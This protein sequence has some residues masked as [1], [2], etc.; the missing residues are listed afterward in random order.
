MV[1]T[2]N[3][4]SYLLDSFNR[5]FIPVRVTAVV[6]AAIARDRAQLFAEAL[7]AYR[8]GELPMLPDGLMLTDHQAD[9]R[10]QNPL[11]TFVADRLAPDAWGY[12]DGAKLVELFREKQDMKYEA[13]HRLVY[14]DSLAAL[15]F[16]RHRFA[17][18]ATGDEAEAPPRVRCL[19]RV[20]PG[21]R[22]PS[23]RS[24]YA[25]APDGRKVMV[26]EIDLDPPPKRHEE[27][28]RTAPPS[29]TP[30]FEYDESR[31]AETAAAARAHAAWFKS[32][33]E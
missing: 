14:G 23:Q 10:I 9:R 21:W 29:P 18:G 6:R 3:A 1:G 15:G 11:E 13:A 26:P 25:T 24:G 32:V 22:L 28:A 27:R 12:L 17:P 4:Q 19:V 2:T 20:P 5:R 7:A 16:V 33:G 8:A 31:P 30:V